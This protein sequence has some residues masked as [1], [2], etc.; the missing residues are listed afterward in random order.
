MTVKE[1][2]LEFLRFYL[3]RTRPAAERQEAEYYASLI[4]DANPAKDC[5]VEDGR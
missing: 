5:E 3:K 4:R 2:L 1:S